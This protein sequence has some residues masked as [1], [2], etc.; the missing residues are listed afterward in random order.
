MSRFE[1][2]ASMTVMGECDEA[3]LQ[4]FDYMSESEQQGR[5]SGQGCAG[6]DETADWC[7][8][9]YLPFRR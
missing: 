1:I 3:S 6:F 4:L 5:M 2:G 7:E 8:L 9:Q